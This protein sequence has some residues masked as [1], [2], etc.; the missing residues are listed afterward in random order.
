MVSLLTNRTLQ[1]SRGKKNSIE[2]L[3]NSPLDIQ[4]RAEAIMFSKA[5]SSEL[6][7]EGTGDKE[8]V[9]LF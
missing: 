7:N 5:R 8:L 9:C 1:D 4:S 3:Q 2:L 6:V